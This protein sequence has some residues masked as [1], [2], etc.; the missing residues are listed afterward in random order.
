MSLCRKENKPGTLYL[1]SN[2]TVMFTVTNKILFDR[3]S[4][5][6][7][8]I[9]FIF[10]PRSVTRARKSCFI[11]RSCET[12]YTYGATRVYISNEPNKTQ[13]RV[14]PCKLL[15]VRSHLNMYYFT[16][17]YVQCFKNDSRVQQLIV[18]C[19]VYTFKY[20]YGFAVIRR[21]LSPSAI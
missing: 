14:W 1:F 8:Q 19:T 10:C 3:I 6:G 4:T 16:R 17:K 21:F 18:V 13:S 12:Y 7:V 5:V 11:S 2:R 15:N 20:R 9:R